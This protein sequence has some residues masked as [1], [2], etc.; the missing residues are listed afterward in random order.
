ME[1]GLVTFPAWSGL[2]ACIT[3]VDSRSA[4]H[5][6]GVAI[7]RR[8]FFH[9]QR[10]PLYQ[11]DRPQRMR[12]LSTTACCFQRE[13]LRHFQFDETLQGYSLCEDWD[14]SLRA[15]QV[16]RFGAVPSVHVYHRRSSVNRIDSGEL[17]RAVQAS[18]TYLWRRHRRHLADDLSY[19]W[20]CMGLRLQAWLLSVRPG[21]TRDSGASHSAE[22]ELL[23]CCA[24][25]H[26]DHATA[27]RLAKALGQNI[28][29]PKLLRLGDAHGMLPLLYWHLSALR[30]GLV[31]SPMLQEL[32][33]H[34]ERNHRRNLVMT[35]ELIKFLKLFESHG[36]PAIPYK[37]PVL[38]SVVYG[39]LALRQFSDLDFLLRKEDIHRAQAV[40][41][42]QTYQPQFV[43]KHARDVAFLQAESV[44]ARA[45]G[46]STVELH[47]EITPRYFS[48][49]LNPDRLWERLDSNWLAGAMVQ[50]FAPEDLLLILCVHGA[51]HVWS[52]LEWLCAVAELIRTTPR[53]DWDKVL[54]QASALGSTR[55]LLLGLLLGHNLLALPLPPNVMQR[56]G[57]DK[58]AGV[59]AWQV[60]EQMFINLDRVPDEFT[61]PLILFHLRVRERVWDR[62]HYCIRLAL[63]PTVGDWTTLRLPT[64]LLPI[65]YFLR[66]LRLAVK[67]SLIVLRKATAPFA[68]A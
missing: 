46:M 60:R 59:L 54:A 62:V 30:L 51:K 17:Q 12:L 15:G 65:Y 21:V 45:D 41:M 22:A 43:L 67:G 4:W 29:W 64:S 18:A 40:L 61:R 48:F 20:L 26:R 27:D 50:S 68:G 31:P 36:I 47:W 38:A 63:T 58:V 16:F 53:L 33:T 57:A 44:F 52:R 24:R 19:L 55:I 7:F 3:Q 8:G 66:P 28:D 56:I 13:V 25:T 23:L 39:N 32:R 34:F 37:G 42:S 49:P 2:S 1:H 5:R 14:F 9:D 6:I 10:E 11:L 35:A